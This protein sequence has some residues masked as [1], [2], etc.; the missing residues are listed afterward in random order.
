VDFI[1]V[2][3]L[4]QVYIWHYYNTIDIA[5]KDDVFVIFNKLIN[6]Q[7]ESPPLLWAMIHAFPSNDSMCCAFHVGIELAW[8]HVDGL[9]TRKMEPIFPT[10]WEQNLEIIKV[11]CFK[12][13]FQFF[14]ELLHLIP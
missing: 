8:L 10:M 14:H 12:V 7:S 13:G 3:K 11:K 6:F 9:H 1:K 5:F 2:V 4:V